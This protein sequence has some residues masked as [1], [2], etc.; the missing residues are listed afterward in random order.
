MLYAIKGYLLSRP[1][2]T[3][4]YQNTFTQKQEMNYYR[5]SKYRGQGRRRLGAQGRQM[6][7]SIQHCLDF[8]V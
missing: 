8:S 7:K 6:L 2:L 1:D 4:A 3:N 5:L